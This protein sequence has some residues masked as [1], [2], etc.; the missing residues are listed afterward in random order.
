[1]AAHPCWLSYPHL[2]C[3]SLHCHHALDEHVVSK[4]VLGAHTLNRVEDDDIPRNRRPAGSHVCTHTCFIKCRHTTGYTR[5]VL[6]MHTAAA[7]A[8]PVCSPTHQ[9][10]RRKEHFT[11]QLLI[12]SQVLPQ[13]PQA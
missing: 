6:D 9:Q 1:M 12:Q 4:K 2:D 11:Q 8:A 7:A 13:A 3:V 10:D 5:C